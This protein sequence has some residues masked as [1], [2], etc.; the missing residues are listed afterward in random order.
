LPSGPSKVFSAGWNRNGADIEE[1]GD[2][3]VVVVEVRSSADARNRGRAGTAG[4]MDVSCLWVWC[5]DEWR[6]DVMRTRD[7]K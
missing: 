2:P 1:D 4:G 3:E 6:P 7:R 5:L